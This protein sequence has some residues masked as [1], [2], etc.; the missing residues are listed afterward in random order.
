[1][2]GYWFP[3]AAVPSKKPE[4]K[5][6]AASVPATSTAVATVAAVEPAT[7]E[8]DAEKPPGPEEEG[9]GG[10]EQIDSESEHAGDEEEGGEEDLDLDLEDGIASG[11]EGEQFL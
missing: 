10:P 11:S 2:C 7:K 1:M 5:A 6:P 4:V 3:K 8:K 9:E